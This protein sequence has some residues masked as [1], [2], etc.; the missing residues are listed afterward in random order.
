MRG[1]LVDTETKCV[2][3]GNSPFVS[4][5]LVTRSSQ[6]NDRVNIDEVNAIRAGAGAVTSLAPN[7]LPRLTRSARRGSEERELHL[8]ETERV[9]VCEFVCLFFVSGANILYGTVFREPIILERIPRPIPGR[10][11][12]IVIWKHVSGVLCFPT[13]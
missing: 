10:V 7:V 8:R 12:P 13:S 11:K 9:Q 2:Y 4:I 3:S 5:D 1:G 6:T